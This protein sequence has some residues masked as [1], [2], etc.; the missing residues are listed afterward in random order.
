MR[1]ADEE[2]G[3]D[4]GDDLANPDD[5]EDHREVTHPDD[6]PDV[7]DPE[8]AGS[9]PSDAD[10][11]DADNADADDANND[12][13]DADAD[14]SDADDGA[15]GDVTLPRPPSASGPS[16]GTTTEDD[17]A[18]EVAL[19]GRLALVL[20]LAH[21]GFDD[22]SSDDDGGNEDGGDDDGGDDDG[23]DDDG[24]DDD[25]GGDNGGDDNGGS[26]DDEEG[27]GEGGDGGD[28]DD[29]D[30]GDDDGGDEDGGGGD[31]DDNGDDAATSD[32]DGARQAGGAVG[33]R[34]RSAAARAAVAAK[35]AL[36]APKA[37]RAKV[38]QHVT[39]TV[40]GLARRLHKTRFMNELNALRP[41][42]AL[43]NDRLKRVSQHSIEHVMITGDADG[44]GEE[45]SDMLGIGQ[46]FAMAFEDPQTKKHVAWYGRVTRMKSIERGKKQLWR[47]PFRL[48]DDPDKRPLVEV[49]AR[50]YSEPSRN[51]FKYDVDDSK[52]YLVKYIVSL[53]TMARCAR[54]AT[55]SMTTEARRAVDIALEQ[56]DED[57]EATAAEP[58]GQARRGRKRAGTAA[59]AAAAAAPAAAE[60][61]AATRQTTAGAPTKSGRRTTVVVNADA[62]SATARSGGGE[63]Q[64]GRGGRRGRGGPSGRGG[65]R[66]RGGQGGRAKSKARGGR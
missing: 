1:S 36:A 11:D 8:A 37:K 39:V 54:T 26:D 2:D 41:G 66:G 12:D 5:E 28:G 47:R 60:P 4:L 45:D 10:A 7:D 17:A 30:G 19:K 15:D 49:Y 35:R 24:G 25:N 51:T 29:D 43:S 55:Y 50:W 56:L 9:A 3:D 21:D 59:A 18:D 20:D 61:S 32:R 34:S 62:D 33:G 13:A 16:V 65:Q 40:D 22:D 42:T 6:F 57:E 14:D 53:V 64:R 46:D 58:A 63:G 52:P 27:D 23:G 48:D 44:N 38:P 31:D